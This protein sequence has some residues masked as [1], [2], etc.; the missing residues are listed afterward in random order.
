MNEKMKHVL[1]LAETADEI[2]DRGTEKLDRWQVFRS[3]V[4][5]V[6][7]PTG[8]TEGI[9]EGC[10]LLPLAGGLHTLSALVRE[11]DKAGISYRVLLIEGEL[12]WLNAPVPTLTAG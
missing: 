6:G 5:T 11:A 1:F 7:R 8:C 3:N 9:P 2:Q 10:W 4:R 12:Q